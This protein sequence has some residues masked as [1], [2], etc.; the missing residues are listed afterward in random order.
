MLL[1]GLAVSGCGNKEPETAPIPKGSEN[2]LDAPAR[3]GGALVQGKQAA[4]KAVGLAALNQAVKLYQAQEGRLPKSLN[5]L[6]GPDYLPKLPDP[7]SGKK[8][9][10]NPQTGEVKLVPQ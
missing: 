2:P 1:A 6:I 3:Y 4:V 9:D 8:F 7:P 10:Y 5:E